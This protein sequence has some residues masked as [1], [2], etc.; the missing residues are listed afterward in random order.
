MIYALSLKEKKSNLSNDLKNSI[1]LTKNHDTDEAKI[2]SF[3]EDLNAIK[4][5]RNSNHF[6]FKFLEQTNLTISAIKINI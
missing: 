2:Y 4:K 5:K 6:L 3:V 1:L